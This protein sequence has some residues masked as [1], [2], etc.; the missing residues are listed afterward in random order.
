MLDIQYKVMEIRPSIEWN[1]G[2]AVEYLLETLGFANSDDICPLYI[3]DDRTDED[4][5]K[6]KDAFCTSITC[7]SLVLYTLHS[8]T[9]YLTKLTGYTEQRTR[10]FNHRIV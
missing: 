1:K 10:L 5:F 6:V 8:M 4:A 2:N 7:S 9:K 3:G